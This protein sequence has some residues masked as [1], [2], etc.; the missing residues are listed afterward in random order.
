MPELDGL[1]SVKEMRRH[2]ELDKAKIIGV[3]ATVTESN[4]R[5]E[6][7]AVCDDYLPKPIQIDLLLEKIKLHLNITW[8]TLENTEIVEKP[9][10]EEE[11]DKF[12]FPSPKEMEE[13]YTLAML[14]DMR[15][16]RD[17]AN[18]LEKRDDKYGQFAKKLNEMAAAFKANA[19]LELI[20]AHRGNYTPPH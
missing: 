10:I 17:W 7:I 11:M 13:L 8:E 16:I 19:I 1:N 9:R 14:G 5:D 20:E 4:R 3:S 6:F 12:T 18:A 15:K 2:S